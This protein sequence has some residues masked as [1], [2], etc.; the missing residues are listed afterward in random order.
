LGIE[1]FGFRTARTPIG[2]WK[3]DAPES[4][5]RVDKL[6][7]NFCNSR[8]SRVAFGP[9]RRLLHSSKC[10]GASGSGPAD[11]LSQQDE[12]A[13]GAHHFGLGPFGKCGAIGFLALHDDSRTKKDAWA[14]PLAWGISGPRA[15]R[16]HGE[17]HA[18]QEPNVAPEW[19]C[20]LAF[21]FNEPC[22]VVACPQKSVPSRVCC[23]V[24][25]MR[26]H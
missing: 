19:S 20:C 1:S 2:W 22:R 5:A 24:I 12:C 8:L 26:R 11:R 17:W 4:W 16:A 21:G 10:Y 14:P 13:V 6:Y 18:W 23:V 25:F 3:R 9:V 7:P 15:G